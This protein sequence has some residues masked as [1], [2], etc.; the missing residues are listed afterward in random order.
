MDNVKSDALENQTVNKAVDQIVEQSDP[1]PTVAPRRVRYTS[2]DYLVR[3]HRIWSILLISMLLD[4]LVLALWRPGSARPFVL[5]ATTYGPFIAMAICIMAVARERVLRQIERLRAWR[6]ELVTTGK[7]WPIIVLG[8]AILGG[9]IDVAIRALQVG[10]FGWV[11]ALAIIIVL[12]GTAISVLRS[13]QKTR[14][15]WNSIRADKILWIEN[16]NR[17]NF[18]AVVIPLFLARGTSLAA[19]IQVANQ[20]GQK[21]SGWDLPYGYLLAAGL[22][23]LF[24]IALR[25]SISQF[26]ANCPTCLHRTSRAVRGLGCC[27]RCRPEVFGIMT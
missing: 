7:K 1:L 20:T 25:P 6:E 13:V 18:L 23:I 19:A 27:P 3:S 11:V 10:P 15:R 5:I 8:L 14:S 17:Q 2:F 22:A 12:S 16:A 26:M 24:L 4:P 21:L 9:L